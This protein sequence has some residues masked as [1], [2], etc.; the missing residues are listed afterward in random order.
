VDGR[1]TANHV[2]YSLL[3]SKI[4]ELGHDEGAIDDNWTGLIG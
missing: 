1:A 2:G 4:F 3:T